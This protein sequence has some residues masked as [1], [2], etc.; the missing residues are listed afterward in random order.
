MAEKTTI[1]KMRNFKMKKKAELTTQQIVILVI[2]IT[3]FIVILIL[4]FRLNLGGET[5]KEICHNSV[6]MRGNSVLPKDTVSLNCKTN[7]ICITKDGSC[8]QMTKIEKVK[9]KE[10]VYKVLAD[11]MADCWWMFG[12]GKVNYIGK[13]FTKSLYC[14]ICS[15]IAFDDS[16]REIDS[17]ED[18]KINNKEFY[19]YLVK[20]KVPGKDIKYSEYLYGFN[21]LKEFEEELGRQNKDFGEID[22]DKQYCVLMG[23]YNEVSVTRWALSLAGAGGLFVAGAILSPFTGG[24]SLLT[25]TGIIATTMGTM[26]GGVTGTFVGVTVKGLSGDEYLPPTIIEFNQETFNNLKCEDIKTLA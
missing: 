21:N 16:L 12:E 18:G 13:G 17:F 23:I 19:N 15:Q 10:D 8:E 11:E 25:T 4:L 14:S 22:L 26:A 6:I 20:E 9:T 7:Y 1:V 2:L 24:A 3:S 5:D